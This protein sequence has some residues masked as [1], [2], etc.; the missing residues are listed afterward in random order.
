MAAPK[1]GGRY[2]TLSQGDRSEGEVGAAEHSDD[3]VSIGEIRFPKTTMR[4]ANYP[5]RPEDVRNLRETINYEEEKGSPEKE[6]EKPIL[7]SSDGPIA[8]PRVK[9]GQGRGGTAT[10]SKVGAVMIGESFGG[11]P[12]KQAKADINSRHLI[13]DNFLEEDNEDGTSIRVSHESGE[14]DPRLWK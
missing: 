14:I 5:K 11:H 6:D 2:S 4:Q 9:Y 12:I 1:G 10:A 3:D 8:R 7:D 13:E